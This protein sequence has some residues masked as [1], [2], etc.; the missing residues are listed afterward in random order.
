MTDNNVYMAEESSCK[1][2]LATYRMQKAAGSGIADRV[3]MSLLWT[4]LH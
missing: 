4:T 1:D 3:S 2:K